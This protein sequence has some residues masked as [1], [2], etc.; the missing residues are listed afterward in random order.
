MYLL[1]VKKS[2]LQYQIFMIH[3]VR[4]IINLKSCQTSFAAK[5]VDLIHDEN[6]SF[7]RK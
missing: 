1:K 5:A 2:C 4:L 7:V 6:E 3:S